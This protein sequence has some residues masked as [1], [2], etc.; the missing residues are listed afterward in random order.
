MTIRRE[1]CT[2][3]AARPAPS[4]SAIVSNMSSIR[5]WTSGAPMPS[6]GTGAAIWR[7]TGCP[8]WA[9]L[10]T[11]MRPVSQ[12]APPRAS[13][14]CPYPDAPVRFPHALRRR[15]D[16][17]AARCRLVRAGAGR[18]LA[19]LA[20]APRARG[21]R[22]RRRAGVAAVR[23]RRPRGPRDDTCRRRRAR[24]DDG[25]LPVPRRARERWRRARGDRRA[26]TRLGAADAWTDVVWRR[27]GASAARPDRPRTVSRRPP[28]DLRRR[29]AHGDGDLPRPSLGGDRVPR[30]RA[31]RRHAPQGV[32]RGARFTDGARRRVRGLRRARTRVLAAPAP[33]L[34]ATWAARGTRHQRL[35]LRRVAGLEEELV[36]A[37]PPGAR[38]VLLSPVARERDQARHGVAGERAQP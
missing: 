8:R 2:C 20:R 26:A 13:S 31:E 3:G 37:G 7:R 5:R 29:A 34:V 15:R 18:R 28:S 38:P 6:G 30:N 22:P 32:A 35:D 19:D 16:R 1:T 4:C 36:E 33:V 23:R 27:A 21:V 11:A 24:A 25:T 9:T 12:I 17:C 14:V 10:R